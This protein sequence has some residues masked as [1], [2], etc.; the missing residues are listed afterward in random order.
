MICVTIEPWYRP[1]LYIYIATICV[2]LHS[3]E[4]IHKMSG[5][6]HLFGL[7]IVILRA[8]NAQFCTF[9]RTNQTSPSDSVDW[10]NSQPN[11]DYIDFSHFQDNVFIHLE[12]RTDLAL[13]CKQN[14]L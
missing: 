3:P 11:V 5:P 1:N 4:P 9:T 14:F 7:M 8:N 12:T 6:S 13:V 10:H 2:C